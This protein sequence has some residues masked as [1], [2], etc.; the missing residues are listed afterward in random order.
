MDAHYD[1]LCDRLERAEEACD[2]AT[3]ERIDRYFD[4]YKLG[5]GMS[6]DSVEFWLR[7]YV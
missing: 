1:V 3:P 4:D 2:A 7:R 5:I 6:R